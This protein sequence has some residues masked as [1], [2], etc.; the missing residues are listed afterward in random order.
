[1]LSET[2]HEIEEAHHHSGLTDAIS[3]ERQVRKKF[4]DAH[5]SD[6][7][8]LCPGGPSGGVAAAAPP[9]AV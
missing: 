9:V 2:V 5:E 7:G 8:G 4:D 3:V 1:M 6:S